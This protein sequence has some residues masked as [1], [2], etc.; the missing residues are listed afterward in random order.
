[1]VCNERGMALV[2]V[3]LTLTLLLILA[4]VLTEKVWQSTRQAADAANREQLFW[5]AQAGIESARQQLAANYSNSGG[6][7]HYLITAT[8]QVYPLTPV[9]V[10]EVNG[11]PVEIYLRDNP[12]GDGDM[13]NDNDLKIFVLARASGRQGTEA[14]IESLCG[15]D[16]SATSGWGQPAATANAP[17]TS[18]SELPVRTYGVA[19]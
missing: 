4:H 8:P 16:L 15:F 12:D 18:L 3:V 5:A 2:S 19:D 17:G 14:I 1:M 10:S 7:Q 6:W 13:R 9:W 11:L